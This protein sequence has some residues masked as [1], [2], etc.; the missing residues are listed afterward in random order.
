MSRRCLSSSSF[1]CPFFSPGISTCV[2]V[3][4]TQAGGYELLKRRLRYNA[5][6]LSRC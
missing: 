6:Y 2:A 1:H 4:E 5:V 3:N